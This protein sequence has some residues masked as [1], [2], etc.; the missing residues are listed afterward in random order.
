M[1]QAI[2]RERW[3]MCPTG[4]LYRRVVPTGPVITAG[5]GLVQ[6][7]GVLGISGPQYWDDV[8]VLFSQ[9]SLRASYLLTKGNLR[10]L[11][12]LR[13]HELSNADAHCQVASAGGPSGRR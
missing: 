3:A 4:K 5:L 8:T 6:G 7:D 9:I 10:R 2:E 12:E 1:I 11:D 13:I